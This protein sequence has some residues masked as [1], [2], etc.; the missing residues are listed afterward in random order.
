MKTVWLHE[1]NN[2]TIPRDEQESLIVYDPSVGKWHVD[3]TYQPHIRKYRGMLS[4]VEEDTADRL[5]GWIDSDAYSS[6]FMVKKRKLLSEAER[7]ALAK[8]MK[9]NM[10]K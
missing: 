8:R 3:L 2:M 5:A 1:V 10:S 4:E 6:S 9:Q 7:E